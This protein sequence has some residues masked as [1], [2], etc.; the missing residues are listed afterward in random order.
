MNKYLKRNWQQVTLLIFLMAV[1]E[2]FTVLASVFNANSLNA[3]VAHNLKNFFYQIIFLLLMWLGVIFFTY[4]VINYTQVVIQ[5]I[6]I[7]IRHHITQKIEKLSYETFHSKNTGAYVSWLNNDITIINE[8]GLQSLFIVIESIFGVIFALITLT[9]YHWSLTVTAIVMAFIIILAPKIMDHRLQKSNEVLTK[10]NE[11]FVSQVEDVLS[12]FNFLYALFALPMVSKHVRQA[13]L[14]LKKA[15]VHLTKTQSIVQVIGFTGNVLSQVLL[16]GLSGFLALHGFV[17]IGTLMAVGALA[18]NVFNNLGN[19]STY[20]GSMRGVKPLFSK[21]DR[22]LASDE[23]RTPKSTAIKSSETAIQAT[24]VSFKYQDKP[25][26]QNFSYT[27]LAKKKYLILGASG[28]GKSTLLKLIA[29]YHTHYTGTLSLFGKHYQELSQQTIL[30]RILYLDQQPR[31][32]NTTVRQNLQ[33]LDHFPEDS[34]SQVLLETNLIS[35]LKEAG[36]FLETHVGEDGVNLSGGQK[37]RLAL[38]R[39]LLRHNI[40]II[41][42]DESTSSVDAKTAAKI[43]ADLLTNTNLTVIM[44]SHTLHQ[45]NMKLFDDIIKM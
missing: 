13:S 45:E 23:S 33:L 38:A 37:Q 3:L 12:G 4:L 29:G 44:V 7:S 16:I 26:I 11:Q 10:E 27:F 39:G 9:A 40:K 20:L 6:D 5:D 14:D 2:F 36:K 19:M 43:E 42:M 41:L 35:S 15:N 32:L 17:K 21:Y 30:S 18:G 25:I 31:L 22:L 8:S 34:L 28:T 24:N 1:T